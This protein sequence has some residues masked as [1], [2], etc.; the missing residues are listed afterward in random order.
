MNVEHIGI[1]AKDSSALADWYANVLDLQ[2]IRR[3]E[4]DGRPPVVFLRGVSG[5]VVEILPTDVAPTEREL[6]CPGFTHLGIV[7]DDLDAQQQRLATLGVEMWGVRETSNGWRIGYFHDLERN[8]LEL[9][10][11]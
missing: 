10:Q 1:Y 7:V 9:I 5:A 2:E 8:V 4:K 6:K 11:R 3:I